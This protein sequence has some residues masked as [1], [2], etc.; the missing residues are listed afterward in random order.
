ML[1]FDDG[2]DF[3]TGLSSDTE[4][5]LSLHPCLSESDVSDEDH[6]SRDEVTDASPSAFARLKSLLHQR[7]V[8][9]RVDQQETA[10]EAFRTEASEDQL[11]T[12]NSACVD[13]P[14]LAR[15]YICTQRMLT[16]VLL[17][18]LSRSCHS[19]KTGASKPQILLDSQTV[20]L[21]MLQ[22]FWWA[23]I[24]LPLQL[25][26][27]SHEHKKVPLLSPLPSCSKFKHKMLQIEQHSVNKNS[28]RSFCCSRHWQ[29]SN[30]LLVCAVSMWKVVAVCAKGLK[31]HLHQY[32]PHSKPV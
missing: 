19:R 31:C 3:P 26:S 8:Q 29:S 10:P 32:Q 5:T 1:V 11:L 2:P 23:V 18:R 12:V 7:D 15:Q 21:T 25:L 22:K 17:H 14:D 27:T 20:S 24:K 28:S 16:C 9:L 6:A 30:M 13:L 4:S